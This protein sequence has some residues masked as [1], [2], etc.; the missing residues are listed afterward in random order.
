MIK[1]IRVHVTQG[2]NLKV[3]A[4]RILIIITIN[5][6]VLCDIWVKYGFENDCNIH[7]Y[8]IKD[9]NA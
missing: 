1:I 2:Y 4:N 8:I 6:Y 9:T 7:H 3:D 5:V